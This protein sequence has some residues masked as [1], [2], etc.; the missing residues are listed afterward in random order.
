MYLFC[1]EPMTE[2]IYHNNQEAYIEKTLYLVSSL[3]SFSL[4]M[5]WRYFNVITFVLYISQKTQTFW[6]FKIIL[7]EAK[8]GVLPYFG[9]QGVGKWGQIVKYSLKRMKK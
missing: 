4:Y 5:F 3:F 6:N 2:K 8:S 7:K 9:A 1:N